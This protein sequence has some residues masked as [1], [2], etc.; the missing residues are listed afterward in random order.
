MKRC[1]E[2][3]PVFTPFVDGQLEPLEQEQVEAH[4]EACP[5]CRHRVAAEQTARQVVR[6]RAAA[7]GSHAPGALIAR[8]A[9]AVSQAASAPPS[10]GFW[11]GL[12]ALSAPA[13]WVPLSAAAT[14]VLAV[15]GVFLAGQN[16]RLDAA[17]AAQLAIDHTR[18]FES[19]QAVPGE[20]VAADAEAR[21][22][23][24]D[25]W[26]VTVPI[27]AGLELQDARRCE[28]ARGGMAHLLY[29][30]EGR[31]VSLFVLPDTVRRSRHLEIMRRDAVIWSEGERTFVLMGHENLGDMTRV[32]AMLQQAAR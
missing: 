30:R 31:P 19:S 6:S 27:V 7:L 16:D 21:F 22:A 1:D 12:R 3:D 23:R 9:D 4:L 24:D 5:P 18:C 10:G 28:Y 32:A 15:T 20:L 29:R 13:R 11:E 2:F 14:F 26:D 25:G 8:C 17:F